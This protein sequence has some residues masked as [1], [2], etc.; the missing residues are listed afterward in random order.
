MM[1]SSFMLRTVF[2]VPS[3]EPDTLAFVNAVSRLPDVMLG[4]VSREPADRFPTA[5]RQRTSAHAVVHDVLDA[6]ALARAVVDVGR[7]LGGIDRLITASASLEVQLGQ[8]RDHLGITGMSEAQARAL[9]DPG[10]IEGALEHLGIACARRVIA[11]SA[12]EARA[13]AHQ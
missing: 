11:R 7:A 5:I 8:V 13:A 4:L 2:V 3:L 12:E 9:H 10:R 1:P 6:G